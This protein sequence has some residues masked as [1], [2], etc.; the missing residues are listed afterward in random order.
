MKQAAI[1]YSLS[2]YLCAWFLWVQIYWSLL[3][4]QFS[5]FLGKYSFSRFFSVSYNS[6]FQWHPFCSDIPD[7]WYIF[8]LIQL[9]M[10][11][12]TFIIVKTGSFLSQLNSLD[13]LLTW[14]T[15]LTLGL[16]ASVAGITGLIVTR[17]RRNIPQTVIWIKTK[18]TILLR[19]SRYS[20]FRQIFLVSIRRW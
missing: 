6:L 18:R 12:Y 3:L 11:P 16:I 5:M 20:S 1:I 8:F 4:V 10:A 17:V 2:F 14:R 13:D 19:F 9:G 15:F 7:N